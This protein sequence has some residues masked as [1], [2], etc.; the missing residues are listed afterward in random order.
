MSDL[1]DIQQQLNDMANLLKA[2]TNRI[3]NNDILSKSDLP[4][5]IIE[6]QNEVYQPQPQLLMLAKSLD[7]VYHQ[8]ILKVVIDESAPVLKS[9][10]LISIDH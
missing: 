6:N 1:R 3:P 8:G 4:L 5:N 7:H 10:Y 9:I 2:L